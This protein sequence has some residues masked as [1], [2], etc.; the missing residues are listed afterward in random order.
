ML[1]P[2]NEQ[3]DAL[4]ASFV[5][6]ET[7]ELTCSE[8]EMQQQ[9]EA[10]Q[11][12]FDEKIKALRNSYLA[13]KL[14]AELVSAE[15]SALWKAQQEKSKQ[16]KAIE[17]RAER[18]RRFIGYLLHGEKF[19]KDGVRISYRKSEITVIEDGFVEWAKTYAPAL[20]KYPEVRRQDVMTALKNGAALEFAHIEEKRNVQVK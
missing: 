12:S 13:D 4:L 11:L 9:I 10:L 5:D 2:I 15:A 6:E 7:G 18:T 8:E 19:D 3:I 20:L 14:S 16:A 1:Y 17:N